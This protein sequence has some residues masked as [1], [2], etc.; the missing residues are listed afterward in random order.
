MILSVTT[1][2][3]GYWLISVVIL[4]FLSAC[5]DQSMRLGATSTLEDS[6]LL[7]EIV[8]AFNNAHNM[9]L[10]PVVAGSGQLFTLIRR[11]EIDVA[12]S[13][14]PDGEKQ[15]LNAGLIQQRIPLFYNHFVIIGPKTDPANIA[16]LSQ[17]R[18][19]LQQIQQKKQLFIS[20]GDQSGTH[21]ME[22][23]L[24][25]HSHN[26][27]IIETGSGMGA[28][29][30]VTLNRNAYNLSDK[31]NWLHFGNKQQHT[32]LWEDPETLFNPYNVLTIDSDNPLAKRFQQ[33]LLT[34]KFRSLVAS[35][36]LQGQTVFYNNH[37]SHTVTAP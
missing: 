21:K 24:S 8:N 16:T 31:A 19:A 3:G 12:I 6:G 13:H 1:K 23:S 10:K 11:G 9:Q 27:F 35:Y 2:Q 32:I 7:Q 17:A 14:E 36:E 20:R 26:D 18:M 29:L 30:A 33:W 4:H 25:D 5:S 22:L 15:L 34:K 28:T 37:S